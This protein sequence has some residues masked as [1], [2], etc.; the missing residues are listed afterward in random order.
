MKKI[1]LILSMFFVNEIMAQ[2]LSK[3]PDSVRR[4][5]DEYTG[6][7]SRNANIK[8][9]SKKE[10]SS[11]DEIKEKL[12]ALALNNAQVKAVDANITI[13]EIARKKAN[14][15]L[16]SSVNVGGNINEFVISN[17]Q[18]AVFTPKYNLGLSIPLDIFAKSK[19]EKKT[20]DQTI[21]INK[22]QK[23]QIENFLKAKVLTQYE[24]YKETKAQVEFQ[25]ISMEDDIAA[26][27]AAQ[28]KFKHC[29]Y[30]T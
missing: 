19:A 21:L 3:M 30:R 2:S 16:L 9:V 29:Y 17:P 28:K 12:M 1:L 22:A 4:I 26:Y 15:S 18:L 25:K 6:K 7:P 11:E 8:T 13:A 10:I 5:V 20:A 27:E 24:N 14:S 23:E